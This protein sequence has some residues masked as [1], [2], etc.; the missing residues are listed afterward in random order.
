MFGAAL[1]TGLV[2]ALVGGCGSKG[3]PTSAQVATP[4]PLACRDIITSD[5]VLGNDLTCPGNGLVIGADN[6]RMDL[7]G[8]TISGPGRG[9]WVWPRRALSSVGIQIEGRRGVW[10]G[11][12]TVGNFAT[13]VLL[14]NTNQTEVHS[15]TSRGNF[16]G[17]YLVEAAENRIEGNAVTVNTY[18]IHLQMSSGNTV[19][20]NN[21][22]TN[23]YQSPGGYGV[24]L[25]E[26]HNNE[27]REN[28]VRGN[29]NQGIWLIRSRSNTIYHNDLIGNNPNGVDDSDANAW[30]SS[31]LK[32][33]NY[34]S[35]YEGKD[36][37]GDGIGET[38]HLLR[39]TGEARDFYPSVKPHR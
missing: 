6:V 34:W 2:V 14:D 12:G 35:D 23:Q 17:I 4:R 25:I 27:I 18:G 26:S 7:N 33:G 32:Q 8:H 28:I 15:V 31:E 24:N 22:F 19:I 21:A 11:N 37:D 13:G 30:Y 3:E 1:A 20:G 5:T 38:P 39:G 9:P 10:V 16:Y 29:Q 36:A